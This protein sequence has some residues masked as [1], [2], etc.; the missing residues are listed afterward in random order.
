MANRARSEWTVG[1]PAW[2]ERPEAKER[3]ASLAS[4]SG[5]AFSPRTPTTRVFKVS[6]SSFLILSLCIEI[7][8]IAVLVGGRFLAA[9][10]RREKATQRRINSV[11]TASLAIGTACVLGGIIVLFFAPSSG[12]STTDA[13]ALLFPLIALFVAD[14]IGVVFLT[15]RLRTVSRLN[16]LGREHPLCRHADL[17]LEAT[18]DVALEWAKSATKSAH[19]HDI[20]IDTDALSLWAETSASLQDS[21]RMISIQV[22]PI[23]PEVAM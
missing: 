7:L 12:E 11:L 22:E 2:S 13:V 17:A 10:M 18:P 8:G 14:L 5:L 20:E 23:A 4:S 9:P 1:Q 3:V 21:G 6:L 19:G 15:R 16:D